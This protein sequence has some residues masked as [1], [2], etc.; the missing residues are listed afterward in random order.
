MSSSS[1]HDHAAF[2]ARD[3]AISEAIESLS[4]RAM[5]GDP[6]AMPS[7]VDALFA[8][9]R[10]R[11][12]MDAHVSGH[13]AALE[14]RLR[15]HLVLEQ[16]PEALDARV[17]EACQRVAQHRHDSGPAK[18]LRLTPWIASAAVAA[19]IVFGIVVPLLHHDP[20]PRAERRLVL[21]TLDRPFLLDGRALFQLPSQATDGGLRSGS[22]VESTGNRRGR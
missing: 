11:V 13:L 20:A 10:A 5:P 18:L 7:D 9:H 14:S 17:R 16:A 22:G 3:R 21:H 6:G 2:E 19:A 15:Q 4:D 8:G 1:E 12:A